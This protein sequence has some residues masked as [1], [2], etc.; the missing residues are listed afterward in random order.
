MVSKSSSPPGDQASWEVQLQ[1]TRGRRQLHNLG[2]VSRCSHDLRF[3]RFPSN[4]DSNFNYIARSDFHQ[5]QISIIFTNLW[6]Q[7]YHMTSRPP[8]QISIIF[9]FPSY[10][11]IWDPSFIIWRLGRPVRF[12]SD[13]DFHIYN[14]A[15]R[16]TLPKE[17]QHTLAILKSIRPST[18]EIFYVD[19]W[20]HKIWLMRHKNWLIDWWLNAETQEW[21]SPSSPIQS[22]VSSPLDRFL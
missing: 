5:I 15:T 8:R 17:T 11:P 20:K 22:A 12:P 4:S 7:F 3:V 10:C 13:S 16:A 1:T 18:F 2:S 19:C 14:I 21:L 6:S 9:R